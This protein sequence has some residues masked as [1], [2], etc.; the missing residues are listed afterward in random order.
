MLVRLQ[1]RLDKQEAEVA[2]ECEK[3]A[4]ERDASTRVHNQLL[5]RIEVL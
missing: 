2:R 5:S 3:A 1:K 4:L